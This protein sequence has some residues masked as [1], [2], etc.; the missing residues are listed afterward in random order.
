MTASSNPRITALGHVLRRFK[1]D[2]WL[3]LVNIVRGKMN[4][5]GPRPDVFLGGISLYEP[6]DMPI[7]SVKPGLV[8]LA[9]L[10]F[11]QEDSILGH[12]Q[13]PDALCFSEIFP[14]K[15]ELMLAY[16]QNRSMSTHM[17]LLKLSI[18]YFFTP[19]KFQQ[20]V[21]NLLK[22]WN[23]PRFLRQKSMNFLKSTEEEKAA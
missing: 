21:E 3:Q 13:D 12:A 4:F 18:S 23:I 16:V 1:V 19:K 11:V 15:R 6:Q 7:L 5:F 10:V 20:G 9:S 22:D 8:D 14:L 17:R 2:E